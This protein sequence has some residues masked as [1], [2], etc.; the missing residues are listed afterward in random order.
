MIL[1]N[2]PGA[3][4]WP[5]TAATFILMYKKPADPAASAEA[6]KFF[7]W[8]YTKG[9]DMAEELIYIPMPDSVV[10]DVEAV[11]AADIVGPDGKPVY[12]GDVSR[13]PS[14]RFRC[15]PAPSQGGRAPFPPD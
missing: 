15:A 8:A 11:W 3:D 5:M 13:R 12:A 7:A 1:A 2:Q 9:D 6:L 14:E 4:T 10:K